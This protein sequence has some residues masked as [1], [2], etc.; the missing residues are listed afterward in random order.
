[1]LII[2]LNA[3]TLNVKQ[4][5]HW[6]ERKAELSQ[7]AGLEVEAWVGPPSGS[8]RIALP[9]VLRT[10]F[11]VSP[12]C[13]RVSNTTRDFPVL[14]NKSLKRK[15]GDSLTRGTGGPS[16]R[17]CPCPGAA[18][19]SHSPHPVGEAPAEWGEGCALI[20]VNAESRHFGVLKLLFQQQVCH[21]PLLLVSPLALPW[22]WQRKG[23]ALAL[24]FVCGC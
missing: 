2:T 5:E 18:R 8:P 21:R 4:P 20:L 7:A 17:G 10:S 15:G 9:S 12:C 13:L 11:A 6:M 19:P 14:C 16:S 24:L 22:R 23:V 1:M 3:A